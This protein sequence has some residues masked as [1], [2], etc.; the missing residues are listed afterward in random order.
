[1]GYRLLLKSTLCIDSCACC[2]SCEETCTE[3]PYFAEGIST[4][5]DEERTGFRVGVPDPC[6]WSGVERE[7][8]CS[9]REDVRRELA[10]RDTTNTLDKLIDLSIR[11]DNL[12]A[13]RG[14]SPRALFVPPPSLPDPTPMEIGGTAARKTGGGGSLLCPLWSQRAH[15]RPVLERLTQEFRGQAEYH[16]NTP[17]RRMVLPVL[18]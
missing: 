13:A 3:L 5:R 2:G 10:C 12:L 14:R 15:C 6:R 8:R 11:L 1:M 4:S 9:L 16:V 18:L 7:G 17:V